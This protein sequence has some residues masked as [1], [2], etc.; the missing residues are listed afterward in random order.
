MN[1]FSFIIIL[2][3]AYILLR[4]KSEKHKICNLITLTIIIEL[5]SFKGYFIAIGSSEVSYDL[6]ID[7]FMAIYI[8][9]YMLNNTIY[10]SKK[11][12]FLTLLLIIDI[13]CGFVYQNIIP[14]EKPVMFNSFNWDYYVVAYQGKEIAHFQITRF[15]SLTVRIIGVA[16]AAMLIKN[17][18]VLNRNDVANIIHSV[19]KVFFI[20]IVFVTIEFFLKNIFNDN[21]LN[22]LCDTLLGVG[23]ATYTELSMRGDTYALYGWTREP[24]YLAGLLFFTLVF[25]YIERK[26]LFKRKYN[27]VDKIKIGLAMLYLIMSGSLSS[28]QYIFVILLVYVIWIFCT[29]HLFSKMS[30]IASFVLLFVVGSFISVYSYSEYLGVRM[31]ELVDFLPMVVSGAWPVGTGYSTLARLVSIVETFQNYIERPIWGL[32]VGIE[33]CHD[34]L[35][36]YLSY[37][38]A[39]GFLIWLKIL[40]AEKRYYSLV[41]VLLLVLPTI[42]GG[43]VSTYMSIYPL[44]IL[45][46]Y[47]KETV[48]E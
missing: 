10:I 4:S 27:L 11:L 26:I 12:L 3:I 34:G 29:H 17:E 35:V 42:F 44:I 18:Q 30:I 16:F 2:V 28:I 7:S 22:L 47:R 43:T 20:N 45:E 48:Y 33:T 25:T 19:N 40:C 37:V 32:G 1:F 46:A 24:S 23:V 21:S 8:L 9:Y 41:P 14:F 6:F 38:G 5:S 39:L 13:F 31:H 36:T 15:I